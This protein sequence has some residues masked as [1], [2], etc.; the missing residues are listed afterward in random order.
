MFKRSLSVYVEKHRDG[1]GSGQFYRG[2]ANNLQTATSL[3]YWQS[4]VGDK[5]LLKNGSRVVKTGKIVLNSNNL[6]KVQWD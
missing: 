5:V 4:R 1:I 6:K 2:K 3:A